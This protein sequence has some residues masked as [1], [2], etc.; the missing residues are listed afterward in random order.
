MEYKKNTTE[1]V[2]IDKVGDL[3]FFKDIMSIAKYLDKSKSQVNNIFQQSIKNTNQIH[4][5]GYYIQRLYEDASRPPRKYF[6]TNK[7]IY[8]TNH[9]QENYK[10]EHNYCL[11]NL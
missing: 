10:T 3:L 2:L 9:T 11:N 8:F 4:K 1:W 5:S 6:K 7:N